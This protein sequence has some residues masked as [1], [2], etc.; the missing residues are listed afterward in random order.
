M[1]HLLG[2]GSDP[3]TT[4][5]AKPMTTFDR[6]PSTPIVSRARPANESKTDGLAMRVVMHLEKRL[7][8]VV[9]S[10]QRRALAELDKRFLDDIGVSPDE[11][12][13]EAAKPFWR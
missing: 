12:R 3:L 1:V 2:S 11:A 7:S 10:R 8:W 6:S 9:R 13:R 4:D 5:G